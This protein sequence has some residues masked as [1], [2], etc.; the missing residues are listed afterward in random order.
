MKNHSNGIVRVA[1]SA[2]YKYAYDIAEAV[3]LSA[4]KRGTGIN[5]RPASYF[6]DKMKEGLAVIAINP[7]NGA[8]M[9]FCC[10]E[11]WNHQKFIANSGLFVSPAFRGLG[12]AR[13]IKFKLF[14]LGRERFP[15]AKIFSLTTNAAVVHTNAELGYKQIDFADVLSDAAFLEGNHSWVNYVEL[16][17]E[18]AHLNYT[19]M[20]FDPLITVDIKPAVKESVYQLAKVS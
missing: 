11:V 20:V 8:W 12:I 1:T 6:I 4:M 14:E 18:K 9:G 15:F 13:E 10:I 7:D 16:M 5:R 17:T 2:D 19:A 3:A